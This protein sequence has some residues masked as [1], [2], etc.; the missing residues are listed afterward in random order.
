MVSGE[1][2]DDAEQRHILKFVNFRDKKEVQF[3]QA[4]PA[5]VLGFT[6]DRKVMALRYK[7]GK[8]KIFD[9]AK[10][11]KISEFITAEKKD[12][13]EELAHWG[14]AKDKSTARRCCSVA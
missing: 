13:V 9:W 4:Q 10:N 14:G 6:P 12:D 3:T 11:K 8:I 2:A 5:K 1:N 7:D